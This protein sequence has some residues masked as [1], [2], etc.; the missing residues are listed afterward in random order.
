MIAEAVGKELGIG[1]GETTSDGRFTFELTN[2]IGLCD[3]APAM[4]INQDPHLD[5][6][7]DKIKQILE[8]YR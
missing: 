1:L 5:L 2:C 7:P 3:H 4:L 8:S 6:T